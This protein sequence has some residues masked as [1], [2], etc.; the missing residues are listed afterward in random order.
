MSDLNTISFK[1]SGTDET[2]AATAQ[3]NVGVRVASTSLS[4]RVRLVMRLERTL[5]AVRY[6]G[7]L[8]LVILYA[9]G[10]R[11]D[12]LPDLIAITVGIFLHNAWAHLL[13]YLRKN[14]LFL[15][16][17][18]FLI[19]LASISLAVYLTG[20][21]N[22]PLTVLYFM[23]IIGYAIS[24]QKLDHLYFVTLLCAMA[25]SGVILGR[26]AQGQM[27]INYPVALNFI[28]MITCAWLMHNLGRIIRRIEL[29][30][31]E[32]AKALASSEAT[33]RA[34]LNSTAS[35]LI[36]CE[37]N[38]LI[39]DCNDGACEF[40]GLKRSELI[41][42]RFVSILFDDGTLPHKLATLRNRGEYHGENIVLCSDGEERNVDL[43]IRS[44][45]RNKQRYFVVMMHDITERKH[46]QE[47]SRITQARLKKVNEELKEVDELR[48]EFFS[49][50][51][52][53]LRSPMSGILGHIDLLLD[54]ELGSIQPE[55]RTAIQSC[56]RS[57]MRVFG[58]LDDVM[59]AT[60]STTKSNGKE[61]SK[62]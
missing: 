15:S 6:V 18:N 21:E 2:L 50:I 3:A 55:Q 38:E 29:D 25:Y 22:S 36:V 44:F 33:L 54:E 59:D 52:Q 57:V 32:R 9:L 5:L 28:G 27:D 37:E 40:L 19:H 4:P 11:T 60:D 17:Y 46:L 47:A 42:H 16:I 53:R 34:I 58:M 12:Y 49:T 13:F 41:G 26:F 8:G 56:R 62:V 24:S 1:P 61:Q 48:R 14:E 35:P 30:A 51:S 20:G 43:M 31:Q 10:S 23:L 45:L 7:Y 39:S